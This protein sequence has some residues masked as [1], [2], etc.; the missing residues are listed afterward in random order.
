MATTAKSL[1]QVK[2]RILNPTATSCQLHVRKS[3]AFT[4]TKNQVKHIF[5]LRANPVF[6]F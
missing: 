3:Q 4:E 6:W 2:L 1:A 5:Q